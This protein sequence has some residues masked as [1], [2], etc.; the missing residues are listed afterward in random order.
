V[1][2]L[3]KNLFWKKT[4]LRAFTALVTS[5]DTWLRRLKGPIE[6]DCSA[7]RISALMSSLNVA[8]VFKPQ[9]AHANFYNVGGLSEF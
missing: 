6:S 1:A 8:C 3:S 4:Y 5:S 9:V 2:H 7:L